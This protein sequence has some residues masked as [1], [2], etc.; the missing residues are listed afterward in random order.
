MVAIRNIS[1]RG[2]LDVPL[3][4]RVV[5]AGEVVDVDAARAAL[6]LAQEDN[7]APA[8]RTPSPARRSRTAAAHTAAQATGHEEPTPDT[9]KD[10]R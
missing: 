5:T 4:R 1:P 10:A 9:G 7:W 6:L 3:L 8:T 2:G